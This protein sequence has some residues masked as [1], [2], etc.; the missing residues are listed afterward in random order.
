MGKQEITYP[1]QDYFKIIEA[2]YILEVFL[3]FQIFNNYAVMWLVYIH[4]T[5]MRLCF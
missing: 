4:F 3:P 2:I 5:V 1:A